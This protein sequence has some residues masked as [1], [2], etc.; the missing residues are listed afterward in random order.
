MGLCPLV[1]A[2][3]PRASSACL[4]YRFHHE[5]VV[6]GS[7]SAKQAIGRTQ[8]WR[9]IGVL[10]L[11]RLSN[12]GLAPELKAQTGT[13]P[14]PA[15]SLLRLHRRGRWAGSS[16]TFAQEVPAPTQPRGSQG[17]GSKPRSPRPALGLRH[18]IVPRSGGDVQ[19]PTG[20][21][22]HSVIW[23]ALAGTWLNRRTR[24]LLGV[25]DPL[26]ETASPRWPRDILFKAK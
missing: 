3:G 20:S 26:Q 17:S 6:C 16:R 14:R 19:A 12:P 24:W 10:A 4:S 9:A 11:R 21:L 22:G 13:L 23:E 8:P 15:Q 1:E 25:L 5:N 18:T 7:V 2:E